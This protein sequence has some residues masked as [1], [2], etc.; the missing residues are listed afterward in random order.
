MSADLAEELDVARRISLRAGEMALEYSARGVVA[1]HKADDSPVT[2]ADRACEAFIVSSLREAFPDDGIL[3]EEGARG[4][5]RSG[6]RWT[7][8]PIDG[9]RD[10][11]RG[12]PVWSNLLA[13][14]ADGEVVLGICNLAAQGELYWAVKGQGAWRGDQ[15]MRVS[16]IER[17]DRA[18][19]CVCTI[20]GL[21]RHPLASRV[22]EYLKTAWAVRSISGCFEAML[23]VS[24][25]AEAWIELEASSWDLAPLQVIAEEAGARFFN[26]D[27]GRSP[28]AGNCVICV[29]AF[30]ADLRELV[31]PKPPSP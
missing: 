26:F 30:E 3:G 5:S 12:I 24:G 22:L 4:E 19:V 8:D 7:V 27:G 9:T 10:F 2:P 16:T 11:L 18:V 20:N 25:R 23:V 21:V 1:D 31:R 17:R 28:H 13:L 14:E 6:R 15:R 29:P